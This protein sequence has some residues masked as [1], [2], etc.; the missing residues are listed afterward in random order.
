MTEK[1]FLIKHF[2]GYSYFAAE[3]A[4]TYKNKANIYGHYN[5]GRDLFYK[6]FTAAA[7]AAASR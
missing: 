3:K 2:Y 7:I 1:A 4:T 6:T 5:S